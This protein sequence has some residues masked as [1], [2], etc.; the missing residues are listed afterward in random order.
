[1]F[2]R[3]APRAKSHLLYSTSFLKTYSKSKFYFFLTSTVLGFTILTANQ[4]LA[5]R[6]VSDGK[7]QKL[8]NGLDRNVYKRGE[9]AA[10]NSPATGIW[11]TYQNGV[12]DITEFVKIHP[13][14]IKI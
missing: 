3:L 14:K 8:L 2:S 1:M 10:H 11:V 9:V 12:Y 4:F 13:G 7:S 5:E 6:K